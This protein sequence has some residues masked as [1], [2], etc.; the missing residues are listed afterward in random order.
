MTTTI[1]AFPLHWPPQWPRD[2]HPRRSNFAQSIASARHNLMNEL[3]KLGAGN[4]VISSNAELTRTGDIAGRQRYLDDTGVAVYFTINGQER[5]IP[6]DE[7]DRLQDNLHAIALTIGALRGIARWGSPGMVDAAF[8]GF[9]ALPAQASS[10]TPWWE[11]LGVDRTASKDVIAMAYRRLVK[12]AHPDAGGDADR[13]V[14]IQHA[15]EQAVAS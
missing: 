9:D 8:A 2:Q 5:C 13:F 1:E 11:I 10:G 14:R 7:W 15:Y 4:I 6:C 3:R 12:T